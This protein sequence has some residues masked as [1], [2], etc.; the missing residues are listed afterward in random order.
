MAAW[1]GSIVREMV[2]Q[3]QDLIGEEAVGA[4][5]A[6]LGL[7]RGTSERAVPAV[8]GVVARQLGIEEMARGGL[9]SLL[10]SGALQRVQA[11]MQGGHALPDRQGAVADVASR[12]G[13]DTGVAGSALD[14]VLPI[15]VRGVRELLGARG[16]LGGALG[17]LGK[18]FG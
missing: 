4:L 2:Q 15:A 12:L 11:F 5:V 17:S 9:G 14:I 6:R 3:L 16:G 1:E 7:D 8:V 13:V 18:L 10:G